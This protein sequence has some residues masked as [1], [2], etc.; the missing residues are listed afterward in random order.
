[1]RLMRMLGVALVWVLGV[2]LVASVSWVAINSAGRQ[3]VDTTVVTTIKAD[4]DVVGTLPTTSP[5]IPSISSTL[6]TSPSMSTAATPTTTRTPGSALDVP[7]SPRRPVSGQPTIRSQ[8]SPQAPPSAPSA[9]PLSDTLV[10]AGGAVWMECTGALISN[11]LVQPHDGWSAERYQRAGDVQAHF[12]RRDVRIDV[13]ATC[14][15]GQPRFSMRT[16][17]RDH[18]EYGDD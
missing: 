12:D 11:S 6:S 3:V 10:T 5:S 13:Q 17:K 14:V 1:M 8:D 16:E 15:G 4:G 7:V 9:G 2:A 18:D